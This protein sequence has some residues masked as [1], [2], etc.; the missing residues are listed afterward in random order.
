[1]RVLNVDRR[2]FASLAS[3]LLVWFLLAPPLGKDTHAPLLQW[4]RVGTYQTQAACEHEKVLWRS[5]THRMKENRGET[6]ATHG[7]E[8]PAPESML[9]VAEDDP[10]LKGAPR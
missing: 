9:C 10:R 2:I 5:G 8:M 7:H 6:A 3:G 1:M 4:S